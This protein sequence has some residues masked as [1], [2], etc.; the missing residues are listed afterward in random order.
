ML[1][2]PKLPGVFVAQPANDSECGKLRLRGK[3]VLDHGNIRVELGRHDRGRRLNRSAIVDEKRTDRLTVLVNIA[4]KQ[5]H[6]AMLDAIL[7]QV[8]RTSLAAQLSPKILPSSF[9]LCRL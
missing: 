9:G 3:P 1:S 4:V 5:A 7:E 8:I 2:L 6:A